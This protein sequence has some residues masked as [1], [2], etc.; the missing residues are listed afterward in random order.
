DFCFPFA[1]TFTPTAAG[2]QTCTLTIVSNDSST[3]SLAV[4]AI[5]QGGAGSLGLSP[6]QRFS[7][8]VIQSVGTCQLPKP[9]VV[10]NTGT[11]NLT[12]TNV[13]I[14]GANASDFSLSGLPA[15]PI[16]LQPGHV[17]GSGALNAVFAPTAAARERTANVTVTFVTDPTTG[18]TSSRT[19]ELCG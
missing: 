15:F 16:T 12:I 6:D 13:T 19:R 17:V 18:G 1:V 8:T 9:F 3:P 7:P 10:S 2:S 14:G 4:Q 5:A 11:C